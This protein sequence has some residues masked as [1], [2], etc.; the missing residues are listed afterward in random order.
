MITK[1]SVVETSKKWAPL[2][3]KTPTSY[4]EQDSYGNGKKIV[5]TEVYSDPATIVET[6]YKETDIFKQVVESLDLVGVINAINRPPDS[7]RPVDIGNFRLRASH[8]PKE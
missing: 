5:Y 7:D 1:T 4:T 3:S 2:K 8:Q 6:E